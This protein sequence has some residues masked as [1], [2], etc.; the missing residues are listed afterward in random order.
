MPAEHPPSADWFASE[1]S[2][3][4]G[5][6][7]ELQRIKR[8]TRVRPLP[9][10]LIAALITAGITHKFMSKQPL[11][12]ATVTLALSEGAMAGRSSGIPVDQLRQ[13]VNTVLLS[14]NKLAELIEKRDLFRLR[15]KLGPQYAIEELRSALTVNIWKNSFIF[16]DDEDQRSRRSARIGLT[17]ADTDP[18][19]AFDIAHDL[20][21]IVI[22][23]LSKQRQKLA[24]EISAQVDQLRASLD[25][26]SKKLGTE[27]SRQQ[28]LIDEA[29]RNGQTNLAKILSLQLIPL[30][31]QQ[32]SVDERLNRIAASNDEIADQIASAG[33]DI[34]LS[35]VEEYRPERPTRSPLVFIVIASVIGAGALLSSAL[36]LGAFD[37][38]V[39]DSDDVTRLGLP[40][41]GHVPGFAGDDIGSMQTRSASRARV[42]SFLRWRSHR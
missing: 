41:L 15:K 22:E 19:R 32:K 5:M 35:I 20:A 10:L 4:I 12:E 38:R 13:Y 42:P 18:D 30:D 29:N 14:D 16:F 1:E 3:R 23:T 33:M 24:A 31:Q 8:R 37:S 21:S 2:T 28:A 6:V 11:L 7:S 9:V 36:V 39:H 27:R 40:M 26:Q 34:S 17:V 25:D